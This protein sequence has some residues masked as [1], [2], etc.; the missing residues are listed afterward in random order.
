MAKARAARLR[1]LGEAQ[2][3]K[4]CQS[5]IGAVESVLVERNGLGRTEQFVPIAVPGHAA[6]EIVPV[7]VTGISGEGLVGEALRTAA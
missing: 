2:Y 1:S 3:N 7:R 5:R 6:G 4:F